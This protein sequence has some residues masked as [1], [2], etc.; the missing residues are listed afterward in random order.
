MLFMLVFFMSGCF[1]E[2]A[3]SKQN[4]TQNISLSV[5]YGFDKCVKYGRYMGVQAQI[6]NRGNKFDGTFQVILPTDDNKNVMY[7]K[8]IHLAAGEKKTVEMSVPIQSSHKKLTFHIAD[9]KH[10]I[11]A[12][13]K[14]IL[15]LEGNT[16]TLYIGVLSDDLQ[17][18][19]YLSQ[20]NTKL[21]S[22]ENKTLPTDY[23]EY[24]TL[25]VLVLN[26]YDTT[27]L[28]HSQIQAIQKYV[29]HGGSLVVGAGKQ[30][31][32]ALQLLKDNKFISIKYK[33]D[34]PVTEQ[35]LIGKGNVRV[36][37]FD[38]GLERSKWEKVGAQISH[39]ISK[40][41]SLY[42][43]YRLTTEF[44]GSY[45]NYGISNAI[46]L[47]DDKNIPKVF[48][49]AVV[50]FLYILL[51]GPVL[52]IILRKK[53]K[54][55]YTWVF[56]PL[57]AI[58]FTV[59]IYALG[60]KTRF[61]EP[62]LNY[63]SVLELNSEK[64][65]TAV[66]ETNFS[67]MT[68]YNQNYQISL[69][70]KY[71]LT[72]MVNVNGYYEIT[73]KDTND[74]SKYKTSISYDKS[75]TKVYMKNFA[76]FEPE[77]FQTVSEET[78]NGTYESNLKF[79]NFKL[80]GTFTNQL[81]YDLT[82]GA[83]ITNNTIVNVG[84]I[85]NGQT[86]AVDEKYQENMVSKD[87][88]NGSNILAEIAGGNPNNWNVK[89]DAARKYYMLSYLISNQFD[90][91]PYQSYFIGFDD[92]AQNKGVIFDIGLKNSGVRIVMIPLQV[93]TTVNGKTF[94]S[95][96]DAY[97]NVIS[98]EYDP[99]Y[100]NIYTD[101]IKIE[102]DF[103]TKGNILG[104]QYSKKLN[105]EFTPKLYSGFFGSI[106][107]LNCK[108]GEYDLIFTGGKADSCTHLSDYLDRNNKLTL[109]YEID[110]KAQS[111]YAIQL[112]IISVIKEAQ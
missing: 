15:N 75:R 31:T 40:H 52:Y 36:F 93:D 30:S 6:D 72:A 89:S 63:V 43:K 1:F 102:Y 78:I 9:N 68:P 82:N 24:D 13:Q 23:L 62:F 67:I 46:S 18:L 105:P 96:I 98:G 104:L 80:S 12:T 25:D 74:A 47:V 107:A 3:S 88:I 26:N 29:E 38:M 34:V 53:D 69:D 109:L 54:R 55:S 22:L 77:Y 42:A 112:P 28:S 48:T 71:R 95:S 27:T 99:V 5:T 81:G 35:Y 37:G 64:S 86:I 4:T 50:I 19:N 2:K 94:I 56:V 61:K 111:K 100:R 110:K 108:T 10:K 51:V 45:N 79:Q 58:I 97:A 20:E 60:S 70:N 59:I 16:N 76:A 17:S 91:S 106:R 66:E 84:N 7:E 92:T 8:T 49:Y 44:R 83:I 87:R 11:A 101:Q 65:K 57:L 32:K 41:F 14:G 103:G 21:F 73:D 33:N 85:G 39:D 90:N